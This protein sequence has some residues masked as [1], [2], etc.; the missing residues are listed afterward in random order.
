MSYLNKRNI[1]SAITACLLS[2]SWAHAASV[3]VTPSGDSVPLTDGTK[4]FTISWD[5]TDTSILGGVIDVSFSGPVSYNLFTP[6]ADFS[7]W[8]FSEWN[9][10][11][12]AAGAF[13]PDTVGGLVV[14]PGDFSAITTAN[15]L[16]VL[17]VN[18]LSAG[19][20]M[21]TVAENSW[22]CFVL[23]AGGCHPSI[24]YNSATVD[25]TAEVVPIPAAV[26][27]F[28]SALGLLGF[29]RRRMQIS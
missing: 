9:T 20:G 6:S 5:M 4:D 7:G 10:L 16:G 3:S 25:I 17:T 2:L 13:T 27:M 26:W 22:D 14:S 1:F 29:V 18:L 11:A 8:F 21:I 24:V 15:V 12:P 19:A 28:G 23:S